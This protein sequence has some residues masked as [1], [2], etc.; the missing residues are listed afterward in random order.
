MND[1]N[2]GCPGPAF[3]T[4]PDPRSDRSGRSRG[5]PSLGRRFPSVRLAA[6]ITL[7]TTTLL[8]FVVLFAHIDLYKT[9]QPPFGWFRIMQGAVSWFNVLLVAGSMLVFPRALSAAETPTKPAYEAPSEPTTKKSKKEKPK[10][11]KSLRV[12]VETKHDIEERSLPAVVGRSSPM[13]FM[14]EK[15]PILNEVHVES[16]ALLDQP[17]SFQVQV[18]FNSLGAR[19]LESYTAAAAG[20]HLLIMTELNKEGRWIAAPLIRRRLGNGIL[21]F[22]P[23]ASREDMDLLVRGLNQMVEKNRK[24]WLN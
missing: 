4:P 1:P 2:R 8:Y 5:L 14:V 18:K 3:T 11:N 7:T 20:R 24:Q 23:D 13:K 9:S 12:Y 21:I 19:I 16:A 22:T 17:G 15:L 10:L 6:N